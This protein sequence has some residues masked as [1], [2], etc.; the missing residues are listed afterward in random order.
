MRVHESGV[1]SAGAH[2]Y[3]QVGLR[4]LWRRGSVY[5]AGIAN[6]DAHTRRPLDSHISRKLRNNGPGVFLRVLR[7][8]RNRSAG[9]QT[10]VA[11]AHLLGC[12]RIDVGFATYRATDVSLAFDHGKSVA[13]V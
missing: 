6:V 9:K 1:C 7:A 11:G 8:V 5:S 13:G 3:T 12:I 2:M 4:A 10:V